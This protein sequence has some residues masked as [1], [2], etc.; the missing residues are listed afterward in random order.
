MNTELTVTHV[1]ADLGY[2]NVSHFIKSFKEKY[3]ITPKQLKQNN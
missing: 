1:A 3:K 2:E